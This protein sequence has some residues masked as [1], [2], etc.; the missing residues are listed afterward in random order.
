MWETQKGVSLLLLQDVAPKCHN[1]PTFVHLSDIVRPPECR[2]E[3]IRG[4]ASSWWHKGGTRRCSRVGHFSGNSPESERVWHFSARERGIFLAESVLPSARLVPRMPKRRHEHEGPDPGRGGVRVPRA[5]DQQESHV[6]V[7]RVHAA[8][9]D[10]WWHA[11]AV[12]GAPLPLWRVVCSHEVSRACGWL[13]RDKHACA[14]AHMRNK[15][16]TR[17]IPEGNASSMRTRVYVCTH[18]GVL[19][20]VSTHEW[21]RPPA[22][23][24]TR[25]SRAHAWWLTRDTPSHTCVS[26]TPFITPRGVMY[27]CTRRHTRVCLCLTRACVRG[28]WKKYPLSSHPSVT[29]V[30]QRA[31]RGTLRCH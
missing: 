25:V 17:C 20:H 26:H 1:N 13:T 12:R 5:C 28:G 2:S 30:A 10:A 8:R 22:Y 21:L 18:E 23:T 19:S 7:S 6:G 9:L 11:G 3:G 14:H 16:A 31:T 4:P 15:H 27:V 24:C 29:L